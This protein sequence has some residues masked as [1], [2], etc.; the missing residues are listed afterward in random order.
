M[1][2]ATQDSRFA[3]GGLVGVG[4]ANLLT[5]PQLQIWGWRVASC[6]GALIVPFG[7]MLRRSLPETLRRAARRRRPMPTSGKPYGSACGPIW[8]SSCSG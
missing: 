1:Q 3:G 6:W 5:D 4:L 7:L 8:P 2:Y